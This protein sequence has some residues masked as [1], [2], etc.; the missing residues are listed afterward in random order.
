MSWSRSNKFYGWVRK[1]SDLRACNHGKKCAIEKINYAIS[2]CLKFIVRHIHESAGT[3]KFIWPSV[4]LSVYLK[5]SNFGHIWSI[6]GRSYILRMIHVTR[7]LGGTMWW[8]WP[9]TRSKLLLARETTIW[10]MFSDIL[11][12]SVTHLHCTVKVHGELIKVQVKQTHRTVILEVALGWFV[13][14]V[15]WFI[16]HEQRKKR[17]SFLIFTMLPTKT[18][19]TIFREKLEIQFDVNPCVHDLLI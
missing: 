3:V 1:C 7:P 15:L 6:D 4:C 17:H 16:P 13:C 11:F 19:Y 8:P 12:P 2:W 14:S 18:L 10:F 9:R 5:N